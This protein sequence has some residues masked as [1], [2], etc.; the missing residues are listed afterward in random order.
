[1]LDTLIVQM[2]HEMVSECEDVCFVIT[3]VVPGLC[4]ASAVQGVGKALNI[5]VIYS[6]PE[7]QSQARRANRRY[8]M[9][10]ASQSVSRRISR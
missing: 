2:L 4:I 3:L 9:E 10:S 7:C 1:M 5:D 6:H 8:F